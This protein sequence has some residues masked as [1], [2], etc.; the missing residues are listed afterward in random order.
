MKARDQKSA[1]N[2]RPADL[3]AGSAKKRRID[4]PF[5]V[6][7]EWAGKADARAY[8]ALSRKPK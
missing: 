8:A 1:K 7:T 4:D 5:V 3:Q 6:F 2:G